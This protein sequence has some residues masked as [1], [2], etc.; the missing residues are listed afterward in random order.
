[1]EPE[2]PAPV[3]FLSGRV[4]P[5][6]VLYNC[7][8]SSAL[9][10]PPLAARSRR[11]IRARAV[12]LSLRRRRRTPF[13]RRRRSGPPPDSAP[14]PSASP[15][16]C[17]LRPP[18]RFARRLPE[19]RRPRHPEPRRHLPPLRPPFS[20]SSLSRGEPWSAVRLPPS[21]LSLGRRSAAP[22]V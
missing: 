12:L 1:M 9:P 16:G 19:H 20:S 6:S 7:S 5:L 8:P 15:S 22:V 4:L 10:F 17:R 13:R 2:I 11:R 18:L 3:S 21:L 14:P